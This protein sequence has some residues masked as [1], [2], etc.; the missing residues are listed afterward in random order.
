MIT[1]MSTFLSQ[2]FGWKKL[3][4]SEDAPVKLSTYCKAVSWSKGNKSP[5]GSDTVPKP[6]FLSTGYVS[7]RAQSYLQ[8]SPICMI[9]HLCLCPLLW[10]TIDYSFFSFALNIFLNF[11]AFPYIYFRGAA[12]WSTFPFNGEQLILHSS[13][14]QTDIWRKDSRNPDSCFLDLS[15]S[16]HFCQLTPCLY[17]NFIQQPIS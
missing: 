14:Y 10:D 11:I 1:K 7:G 3:K 12:L 4:F 5:M 9:Q 15:S 2:V 16:E 6:G 13:L 17:F 8:G